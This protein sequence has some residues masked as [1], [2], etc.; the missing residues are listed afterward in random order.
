M[1]RSYYLLVDNKP[2]DLYNITGLGEKMTDLEDL[3][4]FTGSFNSEYDLLLYLEKRKLI[5]RDNFGKVKYSIKDR[6][7][8]KPLNENVLYKESLKL[9]DE[10][11]IVSLITANVYDKRFM[12]YLLNIIYESYEIVYNRLNQNYIESEREILRVK[13]NNSGLKDYLLEHAI[14]KAEAARRKAVNKLAAYKRA[15]REI[16]KL[17][18]K[19]NNLEE[20]AKEFDAAIEEYNNLSQEY[21]LATTDKRSYQEDRRY[22]VR[23]KKRLE[24][25]DQKL[26]EGVNVYRVV[27]DI[28]NSLIVKERTNGERY[29]DKRALL[30]LVDRINGY[31]KTNP[32]KMPVMKSKENKFK[33]LEEEYSLEGIIEADEYTK[34]MELLKKEDKYTKREYIDKFISVAKDI[35]IEGHDND[36]S[37]GFMIDMEN[38]VKLLSYEIKDSSTDPDIS[39]IID[40]YN[41]NFK[42]IFRRLD[43]KDTH[44]FINHKK[45]KN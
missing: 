23:L 38:I 29:I 26:K 37:H 10:N 16:D 13:K 19:V 7:R 41:D 6:D 9:Y 18:L 8:L 35:M 31:R 25:L 33:Y 30:K 36:A 11:N 5:D 28:T 15:I 24:E 2:V 44:F 40:L 45:G 27:T 12:N 4:F 14:S 21:S 20:L 43:P 17:L 32:L 1:A 42:L 39:A 22:L 3:I 34:F